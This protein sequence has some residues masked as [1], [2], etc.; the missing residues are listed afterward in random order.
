MKKF[1][2]TLIWSGLAFIFSIEAGQPTPSI[3][4][5]NTQTS[6]STATQAKS[7]S[8]D[9]GIVF[10]TPPANWLLADSN[11]LPS[12]VRIMVVGKGPSNFPPLSILAGNPIKVRL[13]NI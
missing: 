9:E 5:P 7:L 2:V 1:L 11:V 8:E 13:S 6:L 3:T 10:F 12:H 4:T